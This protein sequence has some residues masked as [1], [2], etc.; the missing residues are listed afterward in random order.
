MCQETVSISTNRADGKLGV[1]FD[2][3][4][5]LTAFLDF[6]RAMDDPE[7]RHFVPVLENG[8]ILP[9]DDPIFEAY[10]KKM[11]LTLWTIPGAIRAY[12]L[13]KFQGGKSMSLLSDQRS[14]VSVGDWWDKLSADQ[15]ADFI[16]HLKVLCAKELIYPFSKLIFIRDVCLRVL[17]EGDGQITE[18]MDFVQLAQSRGFQISAV[19]QCLTQYFHE[20][21]GTI[22][23]KTAVRRMGLSRSHIRKL[24]RQGIPN[25]DAHKDHHGKWHINP[26]SVDDWLV[27][28]GRVRI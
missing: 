28:T 10:L 4:Q 19:A 13:V 17:E 15:K 1:E 14:T 11:G 7:I 6:I 16:R 9:Q 26:T 3:P 2:S 27:R 18:N 21:N 20:F 5:T 8:G 25:L 23:T 12:F 24:C 22:S